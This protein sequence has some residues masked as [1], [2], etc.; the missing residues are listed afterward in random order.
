VLDAAPKGALAL[1]ALGPGFTACL[2]AL[3]VF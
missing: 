3:D 2:L 1:S